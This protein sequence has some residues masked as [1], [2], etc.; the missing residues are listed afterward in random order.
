MLKVFI[1]G[2]AVVYSYIS[3]T[4]IHNTTLLLF[5]RI[6]NIKPY[7]TY[8]CIW[9]LG[10]FIYWARALLILNCLLGGFLRCIVVCGHICCFSVLIYRPII[11]LFFYNYFLCKGCMKMVIYFVGI[12][13]RS[14][15]IFAS[16][17]NPA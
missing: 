14:C 11:G 6:H 10:S 17:I 5:T 13:F 9:M 1:I 2:A 8:G 4:R 16:S 7:F 3:N 15:L 12:F